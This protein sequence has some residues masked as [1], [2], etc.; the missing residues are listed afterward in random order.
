MANELRA[1]VL[2][3]Y[4]D[5]LRL[6]RHKLPPVM[7]DLGDRYA[8]EEFKARKRACMLRR[9]EVLPMVCCDMYLRWALAGS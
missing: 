7:R 5:I 4:R 3:L 2:P 1:A 8:R 9:Y 6:H